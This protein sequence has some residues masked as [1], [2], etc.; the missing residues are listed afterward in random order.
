MYS[1]LQKKSSILKVRK[2]DL[3][4]LKIGKLVLLNFMMYSIFLQ[5][6]IVYLIFVSLKPIRIIG[7][8]DSW[9]SDNQS[10]T[11]LWNGL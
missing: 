3:H 7:D 2:K 5:S 9:S 11:V 10:S 8:S 1:R 6:A 4:V